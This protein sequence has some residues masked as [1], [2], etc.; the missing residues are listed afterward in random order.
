MVVLESEQNKMLANLV[1]FLLNTWVD[2]HPSRLLLIM[3]D[4]DNMD[5]MYIL[6]SLDDICIMPSIQDIHGLPF[7]VAETLRNGSDVN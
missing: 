1:S 2:V 6:H 4:I 5:N 7:S 3:R